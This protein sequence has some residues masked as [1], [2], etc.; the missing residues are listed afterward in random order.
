MTINIVPVNDLL[1]HEESTMC[2]CLPRVEFL[3]EVL[4]IHN[5]ADGIE[6]TEPIRRKYD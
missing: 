3:E 2:W 6:L 1:E 4:I 5:S